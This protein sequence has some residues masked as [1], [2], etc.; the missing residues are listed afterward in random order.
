MITRHS[1][2][3]KK[4]P[5]NTKTPGN[6]EYGQR[7]N[8]TIDACEQ[9]YTEWKIYHGPEKLMRDMGPK[10]RFVGKVEFRELLSARITTEP[11]PKTPPQKASPKPPPARGRPR[12]K[13]KIVDTRVDDEKPVNKKRGNESEVST[14]LLSTCT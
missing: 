5:I 4:K 10:P 6:L 2:P 1:T 13:A 12:K 9:R 8:P 7:S 14:I 11:Q 3:T